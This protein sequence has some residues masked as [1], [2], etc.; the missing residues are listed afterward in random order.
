[1]DLEEQDL[2]KH[3]ER[4]RQLILEIIR[5]VARAVVRHI[6]SGSRPPGSQDLSTFRSHREGAAQPSETRGGDRDRLRPR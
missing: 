3:E 1:M 6:A 4:V 2:A 5:F